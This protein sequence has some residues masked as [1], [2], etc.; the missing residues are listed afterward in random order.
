MRNA[1]RATTRGLELEIMAA[2][3][4][5]LRLTGSVGLLRGVYSEF[6]GE[7]GYTGETLD[8]AG[9]TFN[10]V[11]EFQSNLS[12]QYSMPVPSIGPDWLEG[13]FTTYLE[14]SYRSEVHYGPEEVR[15]TIQP[16]FNLL[17]ARFSYDF[18]GD[19]AQLALWSKNLLNVANH[20]GGGSLVQLFGFVNRY[21]NAPRTFGAELSYRF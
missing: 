3:M 4:E 7:D 10:S 12:V 17:D 5:G 15:P 1:G 9:Q 13:W 2:P 16:G 8:R 11:P 21:Y 19:Q 6:I 18:M 14:W 20:S